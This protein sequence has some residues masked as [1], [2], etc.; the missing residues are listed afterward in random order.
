MKQLSNPL[1]YAVLAQMS[2][3]WNVETRDGFILHSTVCKRRARL[4]QQIA[5]RLEWKH[6]KIVDFLIEVSR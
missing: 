2:T 4:Y 6:G 1:D 5:N 3:W